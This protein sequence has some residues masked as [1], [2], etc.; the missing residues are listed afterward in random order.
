[1]R[2]GSAQVLIVFLIIA[3]VGM[4]TLFLYQKQKFDNSSRNAMDIESQVSN[5]STSS[6]PPTTEQVKFISLN[7]NCENGPVKGL[8]INLNKVYLLSSF[9]DFPDSKIQ[10]LQKAGIETTAL[11]ALEADVRNKLTSQD[12]QGIYGDYIFRMRKGS[13]D[14][15]PI[16]YGGTTVAPQSNNVIYTYFPVSQ[17]EKTFKIMYCNFAD[18]PSIIDLDFNSSTVKNL[19]GIYSINKGF[20]PSK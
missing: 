19:T 9:A 6:N 11:L 5:E 13:K 10:E 18:H 1:M 17:D 14:Y 15:R 3:I 20:T 2:S 8:S 4:S 12:Y 7:N 16:V